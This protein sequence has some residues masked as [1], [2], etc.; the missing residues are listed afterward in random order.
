[1]SRVSL[2]VPSAEGRVISQCPLFLYLSTMSNLAEQSEQ[3]E[4]TSVNVARL[5]SELEGCSM[6]TKYMGFLGDS[7][8]FDDIKTRYY[9]LYFKLKKEEKSL[10]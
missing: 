7:A 3:L 9:K 10:T 5:L 8:T 2:K 6:L 4:V 1:M